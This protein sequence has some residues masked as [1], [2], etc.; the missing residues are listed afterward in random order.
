MPYISLTTKRSTLNIREKQICEIP[1]HSE[2]NTYNSIWVKA[3][4]EIENIL[5]LMISHSI[6]QF[7][8][9]TKAMLQ[10]KFIPSN[11]YFRKEE[12]QTN[13]PSTSFLKLDSR[14]AN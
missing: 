13:N 11:T 12:S 1:K 6:L 14:R 4:K 5:G 9:T 3:K 8:N 10:D 7:W 2:I